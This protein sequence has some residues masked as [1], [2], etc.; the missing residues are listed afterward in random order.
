MAAC[1]ALGAGIGGFV[2]DA[3]GTPVA[4]ARVFLE[5]GLGGALQETS[6]SADGRYDF[7]E[8]LPGAAGVFAHAPGHAFGGRHVNLASGERISNLVLRLQ[9]A[10][11]VS[12]TVKNA[13]GEAV[14]GARITRVALL[15]E[16]KV[17]IPFAKLAAH[18]ISEPRSDA[19]GRFTVPD[20]PAGEQVALKIGHPAYAQDGAG[21][22][23]VGERNLAVTLHRGV[24]VE[25]EV[26]A[27]NSGE[28][29]ANAPVIVRSAQP[30]HDSSVALSD[31]RGGFS[32]R[33]KPGVYLYQSVGPAFRSPGWS[34]LVL[35]GEQPRARLRILVAGAGRITGSVRDAR[36]DTPVEGARIVLE[37]EGN[38]AAILR[39]GPGGEFA[40]DAAEGESLLRFEA[41][42]GYLPPESNAIRVEIREGQEVE[43]P[44]MWFVPLPVFRVRVE[45]AE[46]AP[47]PGAIVS[48]LRPAQFGWRATDAGGWA[49][50][51]IG[52]LPADGRVVGMAEHPSL[53]EAALFVLTREQAAQGARVQLLPLGEV[54]GRVVNARGRGVSGA[55]V[56]GVF[57]GEDLDEDWLLWRSVSGSGGVFRWPAVVPGVPQACVAHAGPGDAAAGVSSAFTLPPAQ[58]HDIGNLAAPGAG[59]AGRAPDRS[60][61]RNLEHQCG[62]EMDWDAPSWRVAVLV[63]C[64]PGEAASVVSG[65]SRAREVLDDPEVR[66]AA[67]V[68]GAYTCDGSGATVLRGDPPGRASTYVIEAEGQVRAETFGLPPLRAL[69]R[70]FRVV[71]GTE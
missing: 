34:E 55:V 47:V 8:V 45:D 28:P 67:V 50:V 19:S 54:T 69:Q 32:L 16:H 37:T 65:L 1:A 56:G 11:S 70:D 60:H 68:S 6:A 3:A 38:A 9:R 35:T 43:L 12:G 64:G 44:I 20:V 23:R 22:V 5:P 63:F 31:L 71:D 26:I 42:P 17:G 10:D 41:A 58:S 29:L 27:R 18:G 48:V 24:L 7:E 2:V 33:L 61:W 57:P 40:V 51:R 13:E 21:D 15:G 25:G 14:S 66:F 59:G 52:A 62:P 53:P 36:N 46:G 49:D 30:P 39:S 4:G